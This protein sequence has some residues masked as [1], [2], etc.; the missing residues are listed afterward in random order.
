MK[1]VILILTILL[2]STALAAD[3]FQ[4][5]VLDNGLTIYTKEDHSKPLISLFSIVDG[6]SRTETP[7]LSGLSHFYEHLIARG[8]SKKQGETEFRRRMNVLG[9]EHIYTYD[10]G[11]AYGM[12]VPR[13]NFPEALWRLADFMMDL[14]PDSVDIMKER[15]IVMEEYNM[16][17]ADNPEG[18]AYE[19]LMRAAF[20]NCP[21][22]P[23]TIGTPE[24]IQ[25]ATFDKLRTF[26]EERYVPNQIVM[27][28]VGDFDTG[29]MLKA[30]REN[31]GGYKAGRI[32]FE[33][34]RIEPP[35]TAFRQTADTM[36]V[37]AAYAMMGYHLPP[38]AHPDGPALQVMAHLLGGGSHS[39]LDQALKVDS[40]LVHYVY[41]SPDFM[42]DAGLLYVGFR[43]DPANEA[44]ALK[45]VFTET[46]RLALEGITEEELAA[47]RE[48]LIANEIMIRQTFRGQAEA[49]SQAHVK[50]A[51]HLAT[52][53]P[54]LLRAVTADDVQRV[55]REYLDPVNATLSLIESPDHPASDYSA[56]AA[57]YSFREGGAQEAVAAVP[58]L[59]HKLPNGLT[60]ILHEDH[61]S[62]T[63]CVAAFVRG[64]Q[65]LEG[66]Q[67]GVA[68]L[69]AELL[70]K[71]TQKYTRA[72]LQTARDRLG[73]SLWNYAAEDYLQAG[74][75]GLADKLDSGLDLLDQM[76]FH[77]TFPEEE[78]AKTRDDQ[79]QAIRGIED[80][81]W[82][83]T[84]REVTG[85][86]FQKSPYRHPVVGVEEAVGKLSRGD[87]RDHYRKA[88]APG[89]VIVAASGDFDV[90]EL[91]GRLERLWAGLPAGKV[92]K[93]ALVEDAP[94]G[95]L[96]IRNVDK[97]KDQNTFN[98]TWLAVGVQH[99][100]F[101]P[102]VLAKRMLS[103]RLFYK[104]IYEKGIAYRMWTR[105]FPRL[106]QTRFYFEMGVNDANLPV[107]RQ[108]ILADLQ[109]YLDQPL[110]AKEFE[111][112]LQDEI[113]R[114][115]MSWQTNQSIAD[116]LGSWEAL[117]LG[118]RFYETFPERLA[119]VKAGEVQRVARK[120]LD[121]ERYVLVNVGKAKVE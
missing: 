23:T 58:T 85:D 103:T 86:L 46:R 61:S 44:E 20:T 52:Q 112:A 17:Y 36:N 60:L 72:D 59:Y 105:M 83:L 27:T 71:G 40:N 14:Q 77:P 38:A 80:Q 82:E 16:S 18:W 64:G 106:G 88:F 109:V 26:Y 89:N 65:W 62:P 84:H 93:I 90:Q 91:K 37:T 110:D 1:H 48:K 98:Y 116:G 67:P 120:Y 10:D 15:T 75:T 117:G 114:H 34:G 73:L 95:G 45:R 57:S 107:A 41:A 32:S 54:A 11:T 50:R 121:P 66:N 43:C 94:A 21:Y 29:E 8:G 33:Q 9:E 70:D 2:A 101:L 24:V 47:A 4:L 12:T 111:T 56:L 51:P 3:S 100:D 63:A 74:F 118:Y 102:L 30:I 87:V 113:T 97:A 31:F 76:L 49:M 6:G 42:R 69:T 13:E 28:V 78:F 19:R 79:V 92:P 119:A 25:T 115:T 22:Y 99:P 96:K 5:T 53:L 55:A 104:W 7:D 68:W 81:P 35:Q 108:G 39:R